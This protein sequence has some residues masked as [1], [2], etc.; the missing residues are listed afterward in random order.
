[1]RFSVRNKF[2][3][4]FDYYDGP[5][6]VPINDDHPAPRL[7][8]KRTKV[9]VPA[10]QAGRPLPAGFRPAGHG[11]F[12][13]GSISSG[14]TGKWSSGGGLPSGLGQMFADVPCPNRREAAV[15]GVALGAIVH[16]G[17]GSRQE[18]IPRGLSLLAL[19]G[20]LGYFFGDRACFWR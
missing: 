12:P 16:L 10:T 7:S 14:Q 18:N 11:Q 6:T 2:K 1:M 5:D 20:V 13:I 15:L 9:G 8:S 17:T 4:G 19:G 3:G